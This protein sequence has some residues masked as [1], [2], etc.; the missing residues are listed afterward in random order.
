[1]KNV[2]VL[3]AVLGF[4]FVSGCSNSR[5]GHTGPGGS[6]D[7]S[8]GG[9]PDGGIIGTDDG[10][11]IPPAGDGGGMTHY[12]ATCAEAATSK[13]YIGCDYWPTV[14]ANAVWSVFDYAVVVSNPGTVAVNVTVT[15]G[16]LSAQKTATI[17]PG[18][19]T[20][21]GLPWVPA[22]KGQDASS[23]GEPTPMTASV[24]AAKGAYHLVADA[25][26]IVY[27]F[28][29]LEYE[30]GSGNN[31]NGVPWSSCPNAS[32]IP[33]KSYSNDASL[34]LPSTV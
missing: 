8:G 30:Q 1:M 28:N 29:A 17:A 6:H 12:P 16:A 20:Y 4:T 27:Q 34:L 18:E 31:L 32:I 24:F 9:G 7:L 3:G 26:V 19:L 11:V 14:T 25:P 2:L 23:T 10:G 15:G 5:S 13:S 21:I 22:L 33:C